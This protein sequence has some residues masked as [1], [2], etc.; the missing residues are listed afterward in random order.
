MLVL[1]TS[2]MLLNNTEQCISLRAESRPKR[3]NKIA[4]I[5]AKEGCFYSL[6]KRKLIWMARAK[7]WINSEVSQL[8]WRWPQLCPIYQQF[9][10][11]CLTRCLLYKLSVYSQ[12]YILDQAEV[13]IQRPGRERSESRKYP[14]IK[15][16]S[17]NGD[18]VFLGG[19]VYVCSQRGAAAS[20]RTENWA[21]TVQVCQEKSKSINWIKA[22][23]YECLPEGLLHGIILHNSRV[24]SYLFSSS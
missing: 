7:E 23:V 20:G 10:G 3:T 19:K 1:L 13:T 17:L 24:A 8:T 22:N 5:C 6:G 2:T 4:H 15:I 21:S 14:A 9:Q 16:H 18:G 11:L 12:C